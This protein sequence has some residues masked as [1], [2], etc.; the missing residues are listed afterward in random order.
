M[1]PSHPHAGCKKWLLKMHGCVSKPH[2]IVFTKRDY[3][4]YSE[5]FAALGGIVQSMLL[6]KHLLFVGFSLN[7]DN[8]AR[9]FDSVQK[10]TSGSNGQDIDKAR[11][12]KGFSSVTNPVTR[13]RMKNKYNRSNNL[14]TASSST[15]GENGQGCGTAILLQHSIF[16]VWTK[17]LCPYIDTVLFVLLW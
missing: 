6:T 4:R 3:I 7:D 2:E 11:V 8:F 17:L 15:D 5:R 13:K 12:D 9:I 1:L 10:A 16:K 14:N